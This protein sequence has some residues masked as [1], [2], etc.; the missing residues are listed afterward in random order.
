MT[1][2][3][4]LLFLHG[5]FAGPEIWTRFIAPW[6]AERG[7]RVAA[8]ALPGALDRPARLRDYVRAARTA[9]EDLGDRPVAIGHSLGGLVAQHLAAEGSV[10]GAVLVGSPG[11]MGLGPSLWRLARGSPQVLASVALTQAGGGALL[12]LEAMRRA[13]FTE[14]TP[15]EW[16]AG[17]AIPPRRESPAALFDGLTW[18]L[19]FW[20]MGRLTPML[21]VLGS[22][23][24][25]VPVSDLWALALT[26]G[27]ETELIRGGAHGLPIDP[28][29]QS[30][31]WR[32]SLWLGD[33]RLSPADRRPRRSIGGAALH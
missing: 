19:P 12:G 4:P 9:A 3:P 15:D 24:A 27:A 31:A 26:Y 28:A 33:Q 17:L 25:F 16:I 21:A 22:R 29:W 5:A 18:D 23:D 30:L 6:F 7:H 32:I 20:P 11:P 13:L 8:P 10:A 14:D 1:Y 2:R